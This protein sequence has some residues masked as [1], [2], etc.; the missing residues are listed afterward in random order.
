MEQCYIALYDTTNRNKGYNITLGGEGI[1]GYKHTKEARKKMSEARKGKKNPKMAR[2]VKN[3]NNPGAKTVICITTGKIFFTAKE[4]G[5]YY[6]VNNS[7]IIKCC[8][9][10]RKSAGKLSDGT[11]LVWKYV[12]YKHNKRYRIIK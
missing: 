2:N 11:K 10:K 7:H 5:K 6:N 4:A 8:K 12:N 9:N 3:K 1:C